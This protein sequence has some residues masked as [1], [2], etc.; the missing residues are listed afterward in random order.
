MSNIEIF[1][2]GVVGAAGTYGVAFLVPMIPRLLSLELE[3]KWRNMLLF[4]SV[5]IFLLGL[6][7]LI[8]I[9][10]SGATEPRHALLAGAGIEG[11]FRGALRIAPG[12]PLGGG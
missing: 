8:T 7:G 5:M 1:G 9:A 12:I 4:G 2:W 3:F 10:L 11:F 6:A